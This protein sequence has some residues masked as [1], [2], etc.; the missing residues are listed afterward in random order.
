MVDIKELRKKAELLGQNPSIG[1]I[2]GV[3]EQIAVALDEITSPKV[4]SPRT[5][6]TEEVKPKRGRKKKN[7]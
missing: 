3:I 2:M 4:S 1:N 5:V 6:P 7:V